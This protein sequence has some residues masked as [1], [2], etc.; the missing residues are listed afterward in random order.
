V[1]Q[2]SGARQWAN[3]GVIPESAGRTPGPSPFVRLPR[4]ARGQRIGLFGG[5]FNPA[6]EG[7]RQA[8]LLALRRLRLDRIWWLV[9]PGNPLKENSGLPSLQTRI[10]AASRIA[11]HPLIEVTDFEA[12]IGS[13]YSFDTLVWLRRR[14]AGVQFVWIM[15]ADNLTNF[16]HW[17]HWR[18]IC[19][20]MPIAVID[21]PGS[22]I[23]AMASRVAQALQKYRID[24]SD[25]L[26]LPQ[27]SPPALIFLHGRRSA[28]SS[29]A[30]REAGH[31]LQCH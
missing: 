2:I 5:T 20:L 10:A 12:D 23:R 15:G 21:R 8:S 25:A 4:H 11:A 9:T 17:Q 16:H 19:D 14:C 18:E 6:H 27:R 28:L 30:L 13:R 31:G 26:L 22:T 3:S 29:T 1:F 24:E 7:H